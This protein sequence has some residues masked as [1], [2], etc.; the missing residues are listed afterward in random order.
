MTLVVS[1]RA[2]HI[3]GSGGDGGLGVDLRQCGLAQ[4][5]EGG[6]GGT[7]ACAEKKST[8]AWFGHR[9]THIVLNL[10]LLQAV[11][12]PDLLC[13]VQPETGFVLLVCLNE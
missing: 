10:A 4:L 9:S 2:K 12:V 6:E 1:V 11:E 8:Q 5:L 3:S 7:G 13:E